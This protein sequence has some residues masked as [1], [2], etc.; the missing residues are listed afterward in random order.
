V[1]NENT[2]IGRLTNDGK[3]FKRKDTN[4]GLN[5]DEEK[6][7]L[8]A[9]KEFDGD[10]TKRSTEEED[11]TNLQ[12]Q[13][14]ETPPALTENHVD[15]SSRKKSKES[16]LDRTVYKNILKESFADAVPPISKEAQEEVF[17][18]LLRE[19]RGIPRAHK[20]VERRKRLITKGKL[21]KLEQANPERAKKLSDQYEEMGKKL[22]SL[23]KTLVYGTNS[24][25]R[26]LEKG[27]LEL[28]LVCAD[29]NPRILV[30]HYSALCK[31]KSACL[32]PLPSGSKHLGKIFG[33][34]S[35][36]ALGFKRTGDHR[37]LVSSIIR[38]INQQDT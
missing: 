35:L 3:F 36:C 20:F 11:E 32:L 16:F 25:T 29:T 17:K 24:V 28:V 2:E 1:N 8:I 27:E 15:S 38:L 18:L 31:S 21:N 9:E 14:L 34:N 26:Q 33:L 10:E 7:A 30:Q 5:F 37:E 22:T 19:F 23:K 13:M 4:N 12:N 6:V